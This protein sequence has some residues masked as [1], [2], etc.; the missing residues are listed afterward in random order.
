LYESDFDLGPPEAKFVEIS[1]GYRFAC[2]RTAEEGVV[3]WGGTNKYGQL[4]APASEEFPALSAGG[5]HVCAKTSMD[6]VKCWGAGTVPDKEASWRDED[7]GV[8]PEMPFDQINTAFLGSCGL[9]GDGEIYYWGLDY[10]GSSPSTGKVAEGEFKQVDCGIGFVCGVD[11]EG[12]VRCWGQVRGE[13]FPEPQGR[14]RYIELSGWVGCGILDDDRVSC[15]GTADWI[16]QNQPPSFDAKELSVG[17]EF[18]C[19]L[20]EED[21]VECWGDP[22]NPSSTDVPAELKE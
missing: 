12:A 14:Y 4:E 10:G 1:A 18:A 15:W 7:Q 20:S 9:T 6:A 8:P 5:F 11:V 17:S 21:R 13:Q 3:C 22:P 2:G 16:S 19:A